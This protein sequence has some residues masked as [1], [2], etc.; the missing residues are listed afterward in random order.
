MPLKPKL[1]VSLWE[2]KDRK[3]HADL[4]STDEPDTNYVEIA[5]E[6]AS[7]IGKKLVI[8]TVVVIAAHILLTTVSEIATK[9]FENHITSK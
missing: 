2:K 6:A 5:E 1:S 7:R 9:A 8:G 4:E 3:K